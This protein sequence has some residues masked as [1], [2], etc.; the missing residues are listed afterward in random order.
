MRRQPRILIVDDL[1]AVRRGIRAL[2]HDHSFRVRGEAADGWEAIDKAIELKP[3]IILLD[4]STPGM[5]GFQA[6]Y[7]IRRVVPTTK[8]VFLTVHNLPAVA[9]A[10]RR[11]ADGFVP[12]AVAATQ[13][14]P[15]LKS[16]AGTPSPPKNDGIFH[17]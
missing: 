15:L 5:N 7:E 12:K 4:I 3:D 13:L 8:I 1:P 17:A 10:A 9:H 2:F 11:V 14:I 16:L 6:A